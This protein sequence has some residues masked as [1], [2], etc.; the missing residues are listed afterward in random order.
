MWF[1]I[2]TTVVWFCFTMVFYDKESFLNTSNVSN[3]QRGQSEVVRSLHS[4]DSRN[5]HN[6]EE[7]HSGIFIK[8]LLYSQIPITAYFNYRTVLACFAIFIGYILITFLMP[9]FALIR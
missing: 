7:S 2:I 4:H 6:S 1:A 5:S 9:F 3:L 8:S